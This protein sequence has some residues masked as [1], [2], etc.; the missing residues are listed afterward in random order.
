MT[1][2][3]ANDGNAAPPTAAGDHYSTAYSNFA[4]QLYAEIRAD[5]F[6]EDIGQQ[7]WLSVEEQDRL[8]PWLRLHRDSQLLDVACGSGGPTLRIAERA[9]C[10]VHGID[11]EA[12]AIAAANESMRKLNLTD[13]A[14]FTVADASQRLHFPAE[15]FDAI[16]CIDAI[17]HLPNRGAVLADW[18]RLLRPGGSAVFTDPLVVTGPIS[19]KEVTVRSF[20]NFQLFMP[21]GANERAIASAGLS[22][23]RVEDRT[24]NLAKFATRRLAAREARREALVRIEGEESFDRARELFSVAAALAS[25]RRLSRFLFHVRKPD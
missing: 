23:E 22:L 1:R 4:T 5:A 21:L 24:D 19:S 20:H 25:E 2:T 8:I 3:P 11:F 12:K 6:E 13:R 16:V 7:S 14:T 9:A 18:S 15:S 17:C 10:R